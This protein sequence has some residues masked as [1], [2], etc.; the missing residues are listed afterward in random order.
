MRLLTKNKNAQ[1]ESCKLS[2][3]W[4]NMSNLGGSTSDNSETIL[5]RF[6]LRAVYM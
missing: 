5:K 6:G 3:I 4:V 2:F 1:H